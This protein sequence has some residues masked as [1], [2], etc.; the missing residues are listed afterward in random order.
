MGK[1]PWTRGV[2]FGQTKHIDSL[3]SANP[4]RAAAGGLIHNADGGS[5]CRIRGLERFLGIMVSH[6]SIA[7]AW[8][9]ALQMGLTNLT[10]KLDAKVLSDLFWGKV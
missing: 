10:I 3:K 1:T 8:C 7:E 9:L 2:G 4:N 6:I 5:G